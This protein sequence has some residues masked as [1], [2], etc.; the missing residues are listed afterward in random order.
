[1]ETDHSIN[2]QLPK[3]IRVAT[4]SY[5][6][7]LTYSNLKRTIYIIYVNGLYNFPVVGNMI[8]YATTT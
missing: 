8:S 5:S 3:T 7:E 6:K 1:M 4:K 2:I